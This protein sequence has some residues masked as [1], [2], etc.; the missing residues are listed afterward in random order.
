MSGEAL[1]PMLTEL[2]KL[3]P[4]IGQPWPVDSRERWSAAMGAV[5]NFLYPHTEGTP[6][7]A[8][9]AAPEQD[10]P[11]RAKTKKAKKPKPLRVPKKN[12]RPSNSK[13]PD[14]IPSNLDMSIAAI[15]AAGC[16][17]RPKEV[18]EYVRAKYWA[19]APSHWPATMVAFADTGQL[20]KADKKYDL[21]AALKRAAP[22]APAKP[23]PPPAPPPPPQRPPPAAPPKAPAGVRNFEHK[24]RETV[25]ALREWRIVTAMA[26]I[27]GEGFLGY[28][29]LMDKAFPGEAK[30]GGNPRD[31]LHGMMETINPH[32]EEVGLAMREVPKM[33]F[34]LQE[35]P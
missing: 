30:P 19:K 23:A 5:L 20:V 7:L 26:V 25:L 11:R 22:P 4:A 29:T 2:L 3:L 18:L 34:H 33:G 35:L 6:Q 21:P 9:P 8:P 27:L 12:G 17:L 13:R 32:I 10:P 24:G 16:P 1:H 31:F 14:G 15:R 28:S